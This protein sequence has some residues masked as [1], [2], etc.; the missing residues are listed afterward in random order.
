MTLR[1]RLPRTALSLTLAFLT[2]I[3]LIPLTATAAHA[4]SQFCMGGPVE[5][6]YRSAEGGTSKPTV[7]DPVRNA[8]VELWGAERSGDTPRWLGV[9]GRTSNTGFYDLCYTTTTTTTMDKLWVKV[10]AENLRLW[11]VIDRNSH[12]YHVLESTTLTDI[13]P[14]SHGAPIIRATGSAGRA[15]H[16]FDTV[17]I[18]WWQRQNPTS[19]CWTTHEPDSSACTRLT[20][21][22]GDEGYGGVYIPRDNSIHL[23][24]SAGDS[25]H[26]ILHEAAHFLMHRL[27]DG[28]MPEGSICAVHD[29][30]KTSTQ[31]CA[32][33]EGFANATASQWAGHYSF[34]HGDGTRIPLQYGP[35]WEV[36][37]QVEGNVATSL[38]NLWRHTDG[39]WGRTLAAIA[40]HKPTTFSQYFNH[41]RPAADPPLPTDGEALRLLYRSA[42]DYGP[43]IVDDGKL[44]GLTN[45]G[46]WGL[47][48]VG[49][50]TTT[51]SVDVRIDAFS[52]ANAGSLWRADANPDGTVRLTD[53]CPEPLTLTAPTAADGTVTVTP[54]DPANA[55][56]KWTITKSN[57]TLTFTNPHTGLVL[58]T[59]NIDKYTLVTARPSS[60][61]NSQSW[62]PYA[63]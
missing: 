22:V 6:E 15:W 49:A 60:T 8:N 36:G 25:K 46:G 51:S 12:S 13:S 2:A 41:A 37:D 24:G 3:A 44:H 21:Y 35:G 18:L 9:S 11:R 19:D 16:V 10:W 38:L 40:A 42:I 58:D 45:G 28:V 61:A 57:G 32:W 63:G 14:G 27:Y 53:N 52:A 31:G 62:V 48:R 59:P 39:G 43:S 20:I 56:Q 34:V 23:S 33:A 47:R 55:R 5:Y 26:Y 4:A 17:N 29:I 50:C 7:V 54:F 1:L 30:P